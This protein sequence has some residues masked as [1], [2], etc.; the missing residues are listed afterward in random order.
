[1]A[2]GIEQNLP[3]GAESP[4]TGAETGSET[5]TPGARDTTPSVL[6]VIVAHNPGD[7]FDETLE[8]F[9]NQD[10]Q[11]LEVMVVDSAG[12]PSLAARVQSHLPEAS[13]LDASDTDGFSAAA[14][15]LLDTHVDP[16]VLDDL[17]R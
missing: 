9:A 10:Y 11:R 6:A 13:V 7:W 4:A 15:A 8:S 17:P 3:G 14:N 1:M 12:D 16:C 2:D 5:L